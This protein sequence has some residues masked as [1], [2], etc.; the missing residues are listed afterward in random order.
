M[1]RVQ[2]WTLRKQINDDIANLE[3]QEIGQSSQENK[4]NQPDSTQKVDMSPYSCSTGIQKGL[5]RQCQRHHR[6]KL[7]L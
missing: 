3:E 1:R 4:T 5:R 2:K 7:I 6:K